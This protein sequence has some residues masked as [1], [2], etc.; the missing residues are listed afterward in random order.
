MSTI[1]LAKEYIARKHYKVLEEV[2]DM[3]HIAFRYQLNTIHLWQDKEDKQFLKLDLILALDVTENNFAQVKDV[4][5]NLNSECKMVKFYVHNEILL[6]TVEIFYVEKTD[7]MFHI[8][9][10]LD[11]LV[12]AKVEYLKL[13]E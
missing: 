7:F 10:A 4:C 6:A 12:A 8:K 9:N 2:S 1:E 3:S 11:H 13:K 5:Q